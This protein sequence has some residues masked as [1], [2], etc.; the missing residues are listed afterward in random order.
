[1]ED[2]IS[3][4]ASP[5]QIDAWKKEYGTVHEITIDNK[6]CYLKKFSRATLSLAF[7]HLGKDTFKFAETLCENSWIAGDKQIYEDP[8]YCVPLSN[9]LAG[10]VNE[11]KA[12][13]VKHSAMPG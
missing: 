4:K 11:R 2:Q 13:W 10:I 12:D 6:V 3:G 7:M 5:E 8:E 9:Q 1:M